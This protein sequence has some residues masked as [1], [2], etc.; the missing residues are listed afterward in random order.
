M[1]FPTF[2]LSLHTSA[3]INLGLI[4]DPMTN[5]QRLSIEAARQNIDLL[6]ILK[7]KTTGNLTEEESK[8]IDNIL[9][10][11]RMAYLEVSNAAAQ[12]KT[13]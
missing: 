2:L 1:S 7:D 11:L 10:E 9:Y 3:L 13:Q 5:Q 8:L 4:P 6:E 12:Q